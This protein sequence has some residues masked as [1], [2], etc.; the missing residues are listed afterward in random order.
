MWTETGWRR[1]RVEHARAPSATHSLACRARLSGSFAH[2]PRTPGATSRTL[3]TRA[4]DDTARSPL[5]SHRTSSRC[6]CAAAAAAAHRRTGSAT[7]KETY[8]RP[9]CFDTVTSEWRPPCNPVLF[10]LSLARSLLLSFSRF[11][12]VAP[13]YVYMLRSILDSLIFFRQ[14]RSPFLSPRARRRSISLLRAS[15]NLIGLV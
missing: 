8:E 7:P 12:R 10:S 9:E 6:R 13:I 2:S 11:P 4:D 3:T 5:T 1:P 15:W 14:S